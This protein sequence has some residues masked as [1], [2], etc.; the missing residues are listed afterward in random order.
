MSDRLFSAGEAGDPTNVNLRDLKNDWTEPAREFA[1]RRWDPF[2]GFA[3][4]HFLTEGSPRFPSSLL[5]NAFSC[6]PA[7]DHTLSL[8]LSSN[9]ECAVSRQVADCPDAAA[10]LSAYEHHFSIPDEGT[11]R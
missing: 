10:A 2:R 4:P 5:G 9:G 6:S 1:E 7:A 11:C 3:D 8:L